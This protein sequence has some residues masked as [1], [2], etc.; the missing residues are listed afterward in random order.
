MAG[1]MEMI[2]EKTEKVELRAICVRGLQARCCRWNER[3]LAWEG[4]KER[5]LDSSRSQAKWLYDLRQVPGS[6]P[7]TQHSRYRMKELAK[8]TLEGPFQLLD[9]VAHIWALDLTKGWRTQSQRRKD[10]CKVE[11]GERGKMQREWGKWK[12]EMDPENLSAIFPS[13]LL[14]QSICRR[15]YPTCA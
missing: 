13:F 9:I 4:L 1:K 14:R 15:N 10:S 6:L 12:I 7:L 5:A 11:R 8:H 2:M 3:M